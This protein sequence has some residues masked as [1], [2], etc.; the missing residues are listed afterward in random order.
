M[1]RLRTREDFT[2]LADE[3]LAYCF[4]HGG[5]PMVKE[6]ARRA[7]MER[8][9][10]TRRFVKLVGVSPTAYLNAGRI[11]K[12][13][14]LLLTTNL[15]MDLIAYAAGFWKATTFFRAFRR[16]TGMTPQQYRGS[17]HKM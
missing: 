6:L 5:T 3:Y 11:E 10:F 14:Y 7:R 16:I 9:K 2:R 15:G 8:S 4:A 12:A 1:A 17:P 13:K